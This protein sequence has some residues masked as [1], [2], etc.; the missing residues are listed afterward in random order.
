MIKV[1]DVSYC[2][3]NKYQKTEALKCVSMEFAAG[4]FHVIT[5][6]SGSGKTTLLSLIAGLTLPTQGRRL[7]HGKDLSVMDRDQYRLREAAV[8]YQSFNLFPLLTAE[9]NILFPLEVQKIGTAKMRKEIACRM[10]EEVGLPQHIL[11]QRPLM[12]SGGEQQRVAIARALAMGGSILL[13]D[14]PTGN[15]D[16]ENSRLI[17]RLL[18]EL[19]HEKQVNVIVITHDREIAREADYV[20]LLRDGRVC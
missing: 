4:G 12:M 19:A 6:P 17:V 20:I 9:E 15:L 1:E 7:V 13:A 3:T 5:G 14:E 11:R 8:I 10:I 18:K 16:T 2:Y